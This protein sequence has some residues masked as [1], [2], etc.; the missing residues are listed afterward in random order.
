MSHF[1]SDRFRIERSFEVPNFRSDLFFN[2]IYFR[3]DRY[4]RDSFSK[5]FYQSDPFFEM[6]HFSKWSFFEMAYFWNDRSPSDSYLEV[7]YFRS[8]L[9]VDVSHFSKCPIIEIMDREVTDFLKSPIFETTHFWKWPFPKSLFSK[10]AAMIHFRSDPLFEWFFLRFI[11]RSD[12]F[13]KWSWLKIFWSSIKR[14]YY[15]DTFDNY[16]LEASMTYFYDEAQRLKSYAKEFG[17]YSKVLVQNLDEA[18][19]RNFNY[20]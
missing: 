17:D 8:E 2:V 9:F 19:G 12:L 4:G 13:S 16:R 18:K 11:F 20:I 15:K 1:R 6:S 14:F 5:S 3:N 10:S 7:T